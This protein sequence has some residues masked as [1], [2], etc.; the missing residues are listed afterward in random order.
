MKGCWSLLADESKKA[1][2]KLQLFRIKKFKEE[3]APR[4]R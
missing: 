1:K 2:K 4:V 3:V